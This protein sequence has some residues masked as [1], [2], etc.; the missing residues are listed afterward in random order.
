MVQ[1]L[2]LLPPGRSLNEAGQKVAEQLH[3]LDKALRVS[4]VP[5]TASLYDLCTVFGWSFIWVFGSNEGRV[6]VV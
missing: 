6:V 1:D 2:D 4:L 3:S 5:F